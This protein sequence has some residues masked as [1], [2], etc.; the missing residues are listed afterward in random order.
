[1]TKKSQEE[2]SRKVKW[3]DAVLAFNLLCERKQ[4]FTAHDLNELLAGGNE[5]SI[6]SYLTIITR[7]GYAVLVGKR[8]VPGHQH[9]YQLY[10]PVKPIDPP[11][12]TY[13]QFKRACEN[14]NAIPISD[15]PKPTFA[16]DWELAAWY[17]NEYVPALEEQNRTL[18]HQLNY[19]SGSPKDW[20]K[21][22]DKMRETFNRV[23]TNRE[24]IDD[25]G[26]NEA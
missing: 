2:T 20:Q 16:T 13:S 9:P 14:G 1:M 26:D 5:R 3:S 12:L 19:G 23:K 8:H 7:K 6:A 11:T 21:V 25:D 24:G 17:V 4:N 15:M 10:Q 22:M 18:W